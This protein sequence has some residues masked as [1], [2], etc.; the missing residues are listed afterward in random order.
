MKNRESLSPARER[1]LVERFNEPEDNYQLL[2]EGVQG[3][4][5]ERDKTESERR[6]T[7]SILQMYVTFTDK[8][9]GVADGSI[10][11]RD[12]E[13]PRDPERSQEAPDEI[14]FLDKSA[15]PVA[16]FMDALWDQF[17]QEGAAKPDYNFLNIDRTNWFMRQGYAREIS[18][19]YLGPNDF[20]IDEVPRED[21]ARIRAL[22]VE[23]DIAEDTWQDDVWNMPTRLDGKNIVVVDEVKNQG[24]TLSI[25]TKLLRKAIPEAIVSGQY[26]WETSRFFVNNGTE[27]QTDSTPVWYD[28]NDPMGRGVGD[29]SKT[30]Y[31]EQYEREKNQENLKRKIGWTVLSAPHY[32]AETF[33][34]VE[35]KKA[36]KLMQDIAY[37]SYAV[38]DGRVLRRPS[39]LRDEDEQMDIFDKQDILPREAVTWAE[40]SK[41][42]TRR[43]KRSK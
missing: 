24:G 30:Y 34:P 36:Q 42:I 2:R 11:A 31:D 16:W 43:V 7:G 8:L 40:K 13:D 3:F 37:L 20:N 18:E 1:E 38:A 19:R 4:L 22:F 39:R 25:A 32:D 29:I 26:F 33:E 17:A 27:L 23:G 28:S 9:I 5:L 10:K 35:D 6:D 41:E 14:I 12:I 21:L 15:R